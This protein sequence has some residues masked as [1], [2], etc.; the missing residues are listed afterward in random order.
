LISISTSSLVLPLLVVLLISERRDDDAS[1]TEPDTDNGTEA[2]ADADAEAKDPSIMACPAPPA[3]VIRS[4]HAQEPRN[5][6]YSLPS[7]TT[8]SNR[9]SCAQSLGTN[10]ETG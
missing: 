2:D 3:V 9:A 7:R 8:R 4:P 6:L 1:N 10:E 5:N